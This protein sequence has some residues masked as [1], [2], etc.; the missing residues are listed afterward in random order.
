MTAPSR[1]AKIA[2]AVVLAGLVAG[3]ASVSALNPFAE[4]EKHLKG[5]RRDI[6][7]NSDPLAGVTSR[8]ASV[9]AA[10]SNADWPQPHG[11]AANDPGNLA[12]N[13]SG[14][15]VWQASLPGAGGGGSSWFGGADSSLRVYARP[16]VD[17]GRVLVYQPSGRVTALSLANGG[18]AWS[19][20]VDPE[21][22]SRAIGGG[23]TT[24]GGRAYVSTGFGSIASLDSASGQV[25]WTKK[26]EAPARGAPTAAAG[27][28][29]V[30]TQTN[31]LVAL[32]QADGS[33]LWTYRG[34]PELAGVLS[35]SSPA[36]MGDTVVVPYSSGELIAIDINDGQARWSEV[37]TKAM[38]TMAVSALSDVAASPVVSGGTVFA[39]GMAGRTIAIDLKTGSRIWEQDIGSAH[40]PAVAGNAVF[41]L[42]LDDRLVAIDRSAG[43]ILWATQL[44]VVREKKKRSHWAGPLLANGDLWLTSTDGKLISVNASNGEIR[45]TREIGAPG[46]VSPVVASG[47]MVVIGGTGGVLAFE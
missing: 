28:L 39:S 10:R 6:F 32:S 18:Q 23:V 2:L 16:V 9:P 42:D 30:V 45:N 13:G 29:F 19:T 41:L 21:R 24:D 3:C 47:R 25:L 22:K 44:P 34:V 17:G 7:T 31:V 37:V 5:E 36:V 26:L 43:T 11:N 33:E 38:R 20:E 27:K 14:T 12:F 46:Y 1:T 8:A 40:T 15:R 4:K 35:A